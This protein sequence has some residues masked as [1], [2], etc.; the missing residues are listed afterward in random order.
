M[1]DSPAGPHIIESALDHQFVVEQ[2]SALL[3]SDGHPNTSKQALP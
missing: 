2:R 1:I 3:T